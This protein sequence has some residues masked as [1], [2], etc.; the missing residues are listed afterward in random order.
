MKTIMKQVDT[1]LELSNPKVSVY[2]NVHHIECQESVLT[3]YTF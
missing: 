3:L 1:W 2:I